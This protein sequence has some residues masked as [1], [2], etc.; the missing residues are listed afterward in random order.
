MKIAI[1][2]PYLFPYIGYFQL[3]NSVEKFVIFDDVNFIKKGWINRNRI[4][5]GDTEYMFTLPL[6]GASQNRFIKDIEIFEAE[7]NKK[8]LLEKLA[9]FYSKAK[10]FSEIFPLLKSIILN[11]EKNLSCYIKNSLEEICN[12]LDVKTEFLESSKLHYDSNLKAQK[13]I[14]AIA[15]S[16]GATSYYNL[17]GG[18]DLYDKKDFDEQKIKLKFINS[19][20]IKYPQFSNNFLPNLS[21][22]DVLMFNSKE[23]IKNYLIKLQLS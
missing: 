7:Q 12:Y 23:E 14:I 11:S 18:K 15:K 4:L 3:I 19:E 20:E 16:L 9:N 13:K 21:I 8:L 22:I 17:P 6:L 2:Q 10:Y 5:N 1:M